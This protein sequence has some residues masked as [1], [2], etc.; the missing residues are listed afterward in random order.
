MKIWFTYLRHYAIQQYN[1]P[2][3]YK[4]KIGGYGS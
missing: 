4:T 1:W 3:K 2:A